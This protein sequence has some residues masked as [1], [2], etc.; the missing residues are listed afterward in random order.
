MVDMRHIQYQGETLPPFPQVLGKFH[1]YIE[2]APTLQCRTHANS[3]VPS[4]M[5]R[6]CMGRGRAGEGKGK[7]KGR[8][9]HGLATQQQQ[10]LYGN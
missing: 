10:T 4:Q 8:Y 9:D 3:Y 6:T 7:G 5:K 1:I 2:L